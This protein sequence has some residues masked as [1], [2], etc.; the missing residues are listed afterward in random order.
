[1]PEC[2]LLELGLVPY[3]T[4]WRWQRELMERRIAER[5]LSDVLLLLEHLPVYTLGQ[6]ADLKFVKSNPEAPLHRTERGGE[7]TYHGPGQ[8]VGYPILDLNS[9]CKDLHWYLRQL[10]TVLIETLGYFGIAA[11]RRAG[12]TGVWV[13]ECKLGAIG[14]KVSRWVTMHGFALNVDPDLRAF[15]HIVPCGLNYPVG[16]MTQFCPELTLDDVRPIVGT[17]FARVFGVK[18]QPLLPGDLGLN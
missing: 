9:Y 10:E 16:S 15:E 13:G 8:I 11:E 5:S 14:I 2:I 1:M 6:G 12:L 7:V 4:A 18:L 17:A 3:P